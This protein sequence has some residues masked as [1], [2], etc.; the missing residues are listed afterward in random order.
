MEINPLGVPNIDFLQVFD[1]EKKI[2]SSFST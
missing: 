1:F 2:G